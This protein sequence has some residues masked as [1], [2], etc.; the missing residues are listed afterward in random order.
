[1]KNASK[2]I[3]VIEGGYQG[4]NYNKNKLVAKPRVD[5]PLIS[6]LKKVGHSH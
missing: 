6:K 4:K 5:L 1:M 3:D 2:S